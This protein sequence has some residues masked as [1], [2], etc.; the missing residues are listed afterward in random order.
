MEYVIKKR[1]FGSTWVHVNGRNAKDETMIIEL[2]H[3]TNPGG[4]NSLPYMWYKNG[5]TDKI[6]ETWLGCHTYVTDSE[7]NCY[8][9]YDVTSR[10][11]GKRNVIN[12]DW[13]LEDTDDNMKRIIGECIKLFKSANGKS[14][15]EKKIEHIMDVAK[16]RGVEVVAELPK[17]WKERHCVSDPYGA[18]TIINGMPL[19]KRVN[20]KLQKN[21]DF[22]EMLMIV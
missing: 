10:Y 7:G 19:L 15:T 22:K 9:G 16:E 13:L 8:G 5:Y 4:K 6:M 2:V 20:G 14:A 17:G 1:D 3:C 18:T 21:P 12:F 11:D